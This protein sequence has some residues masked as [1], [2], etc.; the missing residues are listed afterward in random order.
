MNFR[1]QTKI[2]AMLAC[3]TVMSAGLS[4]GALCAAADDASSTT[5]TDNTLTYTKVY[6][7][8]EISDCDKSVSS[9]IIPKEVDGFPIVGIADEAFLNCG[10]LTSL[11]IEA[12]LTSIGNYAFS[13]CSGIK[14]IKFPDSLEHIGDCAF[15]Y[16][17][18]LQKIALGEN[19]SEVG[20]YAFGYCLSLEDV[21]FSDEIKTLSKGM[22]YFD[23]SL[24]ELELPK[25]LESIGA[26]C[27]MGCEMLG[28][29]TIPATLKELQPT[30]FLSCT[31]IQKF[32]VEDGNPIFSE[33]ADGALLSEEGKTLAI[34]PAGN[35]V[36]ECILPEGIVSI[37]PYAFEGSLTLT[38]VTLPQSFTGNTLPEGAF[39]DCISLVSVSCDKSALS[40]I[41]PSLFAGCKS[42]KALELPE[43]CSGIGDY[44]FYDC[45]GLTEM[46]IPESVEYLG[47]YSFFGC[48]NLNE[49]TV[50][51]DIRVIG[52]YAVGFTEPV[53][54]ESEELLLRENFVLHGNS[55]GVAKKYANTTGVKFKATNFN[56]ALLY[57]ALGS[58]AALVVILMLL[59]FFLKKKKN[60]SAKE[61]A[62]PEEVYDENYESILDDSD[63]DGDPFDRSY[64]FS[65]DNEDEEDAEE[66]ADTDDTDD[67]TEEA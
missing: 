34:Y 14:E 40:V 13:G 10:G 3:L 42:L 16:C 7:G 39:S 26:Q 49:L 37:E 43:D 48:D 11:K 53:D 65:I 58:L 67:S 17:T 31:D 21:T 55:M 22:F 35:G 57:A 41:K 28:D 6:G 30:A 54:E 9:L 38:T 29:V 20:E 36:T 47:A 56:F 32:H 63:E 33:G 1:L 66:E 60:A 59:T 18:Q 64:G 44:A 12:D 61:T 8:V 19:L 4:G 24:D 46:S 5:F 51:D 45:V 15:Y 27:F 50:P 25:K 52:D 2:G 62:T 23:I